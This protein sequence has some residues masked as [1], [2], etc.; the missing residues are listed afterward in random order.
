MRSLSVATWNVNNRN[1][2]PSHIEFLEDLDLDVLCLQEVSAK[3]F[4]GLCEA[5]LFPGAFFSLDG[6][7]D[8]ADDSPARRLGCA[9]FTSERVE[10]HAPHLLEDLPFPERSLVCQAS[11]EKADFLICSFH[12]PPGASW[13]HLKPQSQVLLAEWLA[14]RRGP[15]VLGIDANAPKLDHPD[16]AQNEWWW[17]D[18]PKLLGHDRMHDSR[19]A[20]RDYLEQNPDRLQA[21]KEER[22]SGPLAVSHVR[23]NRFKRTDSRY[24]FVFVSP[25][26]E[27]R[28]TEYYFERSLEAGSDHAL[29]RAVVALGHDEH[30]NR[31]AIR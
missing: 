17:P 9:I 18:E 7:G 30:S 6:L 12:T 20:F 15:V 13:K 8:D 4:R 22:P 5:E 2:K 16:Y 25:E 21:I 28:K 11:F 3:F 29:A 1:P 26:F 19:D 23:G 27:V 10:A 14:A 24:D 31:G